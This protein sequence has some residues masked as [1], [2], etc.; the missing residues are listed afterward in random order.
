MT[1]S[2]P[3]QVHLYP[4]PLLKLTQFAWEATRTC[5]NSQD[6][7]NCEPN[8]T[9]LGSFES[10]EKGL[11]QDES[12]EIETS[13]SEDD[14]SSGY[15][16]SQ[17]LSPLSSPCLSSLQ[18]SLP[19]T[20][21]VFHCSDQLRNGLLIVPVSGNLV[22]T[23]GTQPDKYVASLDINEARYYVGGEFYQVGLTF[24]SLVNDH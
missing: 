13:S 21:L 2:V 1:T 24:V 6:F 10:D 14:P 20:R 22:V 12:T 15:Q 4:T 8:V 5:K 3:P 17:A 19:P 16:T 7:S 9:L 11:F 23:S 18:W